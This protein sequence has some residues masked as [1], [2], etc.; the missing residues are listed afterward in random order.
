M[1]D[2]PFTKMATK[3]GYKVHKLSIEPLFGV[4]LRINVSPTEQEAVIEVC[5]GRTSINIFEA[6]P[7]DLSYI[8]KFKR[9]SIFQN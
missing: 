9:V 6:F 3:H 7:Y 1:R 5:K 8:I 2:I 4:I